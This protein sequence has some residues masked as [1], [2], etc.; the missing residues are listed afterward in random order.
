MITTLVLN[1]FYAFAYGISLIVASFGDVVPNNLITTSIV[2]IKGYYMSLNS[3]VPLET[4]VAIIIFD[5]TFE[6]A[7]FIYKLVRWGYKKVPTIS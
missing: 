3:I 2:T 5:L 6:T 1:I 7:V 4:I